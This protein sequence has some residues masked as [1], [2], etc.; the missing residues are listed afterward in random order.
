MPLA[1]L[2]PRE[3]LLAHLDF[4]SSAFAASGLP[5]ALYVDYHSFFFTHQP[6]AFTQLGAALRF[7]EVSLRYAPTPQAK[8]KIERLHDFWQKRLPAVFAAEGIA[9]L[10]PA[11]ALLDAWRIHR[12]AEEKHR[13]IGSTPQAAWKLALREKRSAL[14]PAPACP[15]WP[16]VWSQRA[17]TRVDPDG[18][19]ALGAVRLRISKP[20]GAKVVRCLHPNGDHSVLA[21]PPHKDTKPVLLLHSPAP[22]SVLL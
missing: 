1:R 17:N 8:G 5:L 4:L 22:S 20:P 7:Y 6:D 13:E 21:A 19:I 12:N 14:R 3:S 2:Y 18:R 15:W 10:A 11:N 9:T 16:Y